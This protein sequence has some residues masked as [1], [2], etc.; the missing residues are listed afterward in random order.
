MESGALALLKQAALYRERWLANFYQIGLRAIAGREGWP[1]AFLI[2]A[3]GQNQDGLA[4]MLRILVTGDVEVRQA[5]TGFSVGGR[6]YAAGTY[7]VMMDQPYSAFAKTLLEVQHYPE[8]EEYPG[9][10]VRAPYDV[11]AHTLPL[12]MGVEVIA[13]DEAPAVELSEPI[14]VPSHEKLAPRVTDRGRQPRIAVYEPW[15]PLIDA[16]WTRWLLDQYGIDYEQLRDADARSGDLRERFDAI[17]LPDGSPRR[18]IEGYEEGTMPP[19]YVGGLGEAGVAALEEFVAAG[20]T[21][22]AFNNASMLPI[23]EF[24]LP[25]VNVLGELEREEFYVPGSILRLDLE[26]GHWLTEGVPTRTAAW[27]ERGLAF[28]PKEG[29]AAG[30]LEIVGRYG[31]EDLLLSGW[32]TGEQHI[33]G[34]GA[35]AVIEH[36]LGRVILFGF[37]PQYRGQTIATYPLI[38]N[39]LAGSPHGASARN[40]PDRTGPDR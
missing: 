28:E 38:F 33:A 18:M 23:E 21:L 6:R 35:L 27:F 10:P 34:H 13:I 39:A 2:P 22:L 5:R 19:R 16:G 1:G 11:T 7:V 4:D 24:D 14:E 15:W 37:K 3:D 30:E 26:P 36:G 20:G 8:L 29:A 40:I 31:E 9:G 32:I 17:I 25:V 12:L